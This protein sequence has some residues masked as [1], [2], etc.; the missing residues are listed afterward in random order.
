VLFTTELVVSVGPNGTKSACR[1]GQKE[2]KAYFFGVWKKY[3]KFSVLS[4]DFT[5]MSGQ[6]FLKVNCDLWKALN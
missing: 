6:C 5:L 3:T 1:E 4:R 2:A